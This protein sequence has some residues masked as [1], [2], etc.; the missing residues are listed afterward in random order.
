MNNCSR[1]RSFP[2][3]SSNIKKLDIRS[4]KIEDF[5]PSV[6]GR[7]LCLDLLFIGSKSL[8]RLRHVPESVTKLDL[9][10]SDIQRIPDCVIG[11]LHLV[12]LIVENCTKLVSIPDLPPSLES[13]NAN[14]CA[15]LKR[16]CCPFHNPIKILTFYNCL[17]LD[18]EA[19]RGIIRQRAFSYI[20]LPGKEVPAQFTYRATG[21]YITIPLA[22]GGEGTLPASSR[23]KACLLISPI[24]DYRVLTITC[25][26]RSK[27]GLQLNSIHYFARLSSDMSPRSLSGHLFVFDGDLFD[28]QNICHEVGGTMREILF[29][30][31]CW[32]ND[33]KIIECGVQLLTEEAEN[34]R[35][36]KV[37]NFE[38]VRIRNHHTDEAVHT[39]RR[40]ILSGEEDKISITLWIFVAL[41]IFGMIQI[42][43][44][45]GTSN[46]RCYY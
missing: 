33:D 24:K 41:C 10:N 23:F 46:P 26:L 19:R 18:E 20:C 42:F 4:T 8:N 40:K 31:S 7:W 12:D 14:H 1:L 44:E 2:D 5:P 17:S 45:I 21:N 43:R 35:N 11:L 13:L 34:S 25:H 36:N 30:F 15:S 9:R 16:V 28:E 3:I 22:S 39:G 27:G 37:K 29:E 6:V 38:I 32:Y